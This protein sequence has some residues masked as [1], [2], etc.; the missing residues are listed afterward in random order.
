MALFKILKGDSSRIG[1]DVTEFHEGYAYFTPD[2]GGF[3]IDAVTRG[4]NKRIKINPSGNNTS[5]NAVLTV[6]GWN[7]NV[8]TVTVAGMTAS[9]NGQVG[10]AQSATAAQVQAATNA[11]MRVISQSENSLTV[12]AGGDVPTIDIPITIIML[13]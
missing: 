5:V 9:K 1:T 4:E 2:D 13:G 3:Y 12:I 11:S 8:Q 7:N 6:A 10:I